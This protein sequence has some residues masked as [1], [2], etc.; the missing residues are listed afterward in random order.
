MPDNKCEEDERGEGTSDGGRARQAG[1]LAAWRPEVAWCENCRAKARLRERLRYAR[2]AVRFVKDSLDSE[3]QREIV[4]HEQL[5]AAP[6]EI[7]C[8][9]VL[10]GGEEL[11]CENAANIRLR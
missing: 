11:R 5:N 3:L 9:P 7:D 6:S 10:C 1:A 2:E 4:V 8:S